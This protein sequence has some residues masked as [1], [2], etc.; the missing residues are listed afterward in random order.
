MRKILS[1]FFNNDRAYAARLEL[2]ET[3]IKVSKIDATEKRLDLLA[4]TEQDSIDA[5]AELQ[6]FV[7]EMGEDADEVRVTFSMDAAFARQLPNASNAT[8][9]ELSKLVNFEIRQAFPSLDPKE[10]ETRIIEFAPRVD[11]TKNYFAAILDKRLINAAKMIIE[12]LKPIDRFEISQMN[13]H[14]A[15]LY[16]YP[17]YADNSALFIGAQDSFID[18]SLIQKGQPIYYNL[19]ALQDRDNLAPTVIQELEK[20]QM[21]CVAFVDCIVFFG[22]GLTN[23]SLDK[24]KSELLGMASYVGKLNPFRMALADLSDRQK[25]YCSRIAHILPPLIGAAL[26][27]QYKLIEVIE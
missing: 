1:I 12:I 2:T 27:P 10:F 26:E 5:S 9:E 23:A 4:L 7:F 17:E 22:S 19:I 24:A 20:A 15:F 3:G 21:D 11:G 18:I 8:K 14:N 6:E 13:A 16:N 25:Q